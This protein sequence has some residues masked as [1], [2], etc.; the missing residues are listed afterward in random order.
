MIKRHIPQPDPDPWSDEFCAEPDPRIRMPSGGGMRLGDNN[1]QYE[2]ALRK[3]RDHPSNLEDQAFRR[4][5]FG[6][7][8]ITSTAIPGRRR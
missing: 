5:V 6:D 7:P 2:I 3:L 1:A 8:P 4:P